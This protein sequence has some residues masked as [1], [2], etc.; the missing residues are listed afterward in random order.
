MSIKEEFYKR[1]SFFMIISTIFISVTSVAV[2]RKIVINDMRDKGDSIARI[3]S[4]VAKDSMLVHDYVTME[5]YVREIVNDSNI[6]SL[7]VTRSDGEIIA[8]AVSEETKE[9][10]YNLRYPITI[11]ESALGT[12]DIN[13][14]TERVNSI[15]K[16]IIITAVVFI[17][18]VHGIAFFVNNVIISRLI[19]L[20]LRSFAQAV[21][22]LRD[23][24]MQA[25]IDMNTENE[26]KDLASA[27]NTMAD[28]IE[29]NFREIM[30]KQTEIKAEKSKFEAIVK[31]LADG[32]FVTNRDGIIISFNH[33]ATIITGYS[34]DEVIG[35]YCE[36]VFKT[37]LCEDACALYNED[38][39]IRNKETE[40]ISKDGLRRMVSVSSAIIRQD[41]GKVL[42]GVQTFRDITDE[43]QKQAML[44]HTEKLAAIGLLSAGLAHEINNPMGNILG[45]AKLML[46]DHS[47]SDKQ[48]QRLEIISEQAE[49]AG[50]IVRRLLN[51]SRQ[52]KPEMERI[53][54]NNLIENV[55]S[56]ISLE[57]EK[58]NIDI[59]MELSDLPDI[60][61]DIKQIEQVLFNIIINAVQAI[62]SDGVITINTLQTDSSFIEV[63][64][65]DTGPG[66][67]P[68][69][70]NRIFDPFYTTKPVNKGTG[71][72][73][74][75]CM[76]IIK[77]H[78]GGIEV[79]SE[80]G[81]GAT[82]IIKL[83][84]WKD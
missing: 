46:K 47:L 6:R 49:K 83:P 69:H 79:Q 54:I 62:E 30:E 29:K 67:H 65:K 10:G 56:L 71:L 63:R 32:L 16:K 40:L 33:A 81:K 68:E 45:Y 3:L 21:K 31:S 37:K 22:S 57:A 7:I 42:G 75:I 25:R 74:S 58:K 11:G 51:Y 20:P 60:K 28:T 70:I 2:V 61:A 73:L 13:F 50:T 34:E 18:I 59:N 41:D 35:K 8:K 12:I 26:F 36:D 5:R 38:K 84:V 76:G 55:I 53:S 77:E 64:I 39:I 15:S 17:V 66:I 44:C 23:G 27:F 72:G 80:Y 43:K 82:F 1:L 48:R 78:N 9:K 19:V 14:S 4:T 24:M 52:H